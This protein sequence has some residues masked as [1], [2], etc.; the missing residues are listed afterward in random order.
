M[1]GQFD[2]A[3][4]VILTKKNDLKCG[5]IKTHVPSDNLTRIFIRFPTDGQINEI[6][7]QQ[8]HALKKLSDNELIAEYN[9]I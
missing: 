6:L 8:I 4:Y 1:Q 2:S 5:N 9:I 7:F 3:T